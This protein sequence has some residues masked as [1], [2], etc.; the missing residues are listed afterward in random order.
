[1]PENKEELI[2]LLNYHV[3]AG[4]SSAADVGKLTMAKTVNGQSAPIVVSGGKISID[5]AELTARDILSSNGIVHGIDK[6]NIP[7]KQYPQPAVTAGCTD[8]GAQAPSFLW[9]TQSVRPIPIARMDAGMAGGENWAETFAHAALGEAE[10][11]RERMNLAFCQG[12]E[13]A[14]PLVGSPRTSPR[15]LPV[16][17]AR[18]VQDSSSPI[19]TCRSTAPCRTR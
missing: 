12:A 16:G 6:V 9:A 18:Q 13:P 14:L 10:R 4:S 1:M 8:D 3:L 17:N 2:A 7:T 19:L 5:G 15:P 11:A